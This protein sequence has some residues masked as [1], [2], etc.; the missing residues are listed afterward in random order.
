MVILLAPW[1]PSDATRQLARDVADA[2]D[3]RFPSRGV[4]ADAL[5]LKLPEL[6]LQL[7][8]QKALNL[9]RLT[10]LDAEFWNGLLGILAQRMGGSYLSPDLVLLLKGAATLRR[11]PAKMRLEQRAERRLA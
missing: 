10:A 6:S 4:A 3:M 7:S 1:T 5:G 9:W 8:G 11:V 2:L